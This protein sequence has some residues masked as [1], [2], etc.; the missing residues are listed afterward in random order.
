MLNSSEAATRLARNTDATPAGTLPVKVTAVRNVA[1]MAGTTT[2]FR[3]TMT[4]ISEARPA[5]YTQCAGV[6]SMVVS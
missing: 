2:F 5:R 3:A 6:I 1:A 4:M